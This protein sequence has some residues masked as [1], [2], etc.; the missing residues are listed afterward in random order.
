M[1]MPSIFN[2]RLFED[3]MDFPF[4]SVFSDKQNPIVKNYTAGMM[5]TDIKDK[6]GFYELDMELPGFKKEDVNAQ[7]KD[8]YLT[9][10]ANQNVSNEEKDEKGNYIRQERYTGQCSRSF[11]V[12]KD[13]KEEDIKAKFENGMLYLKFPKEDAREKVEENKFIAIEG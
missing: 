12:G 6:D 9:I 5:K 11:F 7:L 8:G 4:R 1:L 13:L 3:W 10:T 2:D